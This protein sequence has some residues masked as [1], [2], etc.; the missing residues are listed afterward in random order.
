MLDFSRRINRLTY[1]CGMLLAYVSVSLF[2]LIM[3]TIL[4]QTPYSGELFSHGPGWML[5]GIAALIITPSVLIAFL[6]Y[7]LALTRQRAN[8]LSENHA[9]AIMLAAY[10]IAPGNIIIALIPGQEHANKYGHKPR[11]GFDL[12]PKRPD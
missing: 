6:I 12:R 10:L 9:L 3:I 11:K 4:D 8:D 2:F 1:T 5:V 7:T